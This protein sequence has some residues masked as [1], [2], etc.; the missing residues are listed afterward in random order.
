MKLIRFIKLMLT[1]TAFSLTYIHLQMQIFDLAYKGK[2]KEKQIREL[3]DENGRIR[4]NILSL[5]SSNSLGVKLLKEHSG[6][7]F[8]DNDNIV[9]LVTTDKFFINNNLAAQKN[10]E[11]QTNFLFSFLTLRSQ[12]EAKQIE[13]FKKY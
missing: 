13:K 1:V 7:K 4:Y 3:S 12:A 8:V 9:R 5:Q 6:M 10:S 2:M 11:R